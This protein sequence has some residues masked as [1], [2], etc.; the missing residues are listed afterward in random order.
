MPAVL[1][2]PASVRSTTRST[3]RFKTEPETVADL[4]SLERKLEEILEAGEYSAPPNLVASFFG[5][6]EWVVRP[7]TERDRSRFAKM[8]QDVKASIA[9]VTA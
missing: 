2:Y 4:L 7:L 3:T 6:T 5:S 9:R 1:Q 8:L